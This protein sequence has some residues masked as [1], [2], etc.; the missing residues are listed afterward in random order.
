[1]SLLDRLCRTTVLDEIRQLVESARRGGSARSRGGPRRGGGARRA[2][3]RFARSHSP[4]VGRH[5]EIVVAVPDRHGHGD[6][7]EVEAPR[8]HQGAVVVVE[9]PLP[10]GEGVTQRGGQLDARRGRLERDGSGALEA[11]RRMTAMMFVSGHLA[12]LARRF[13]QRRLELRAAAT[14][15]ARTPRCSAGPIP[16]VQSKSASI[17]AT[18]GQR[19]TPHDSAARRARRTRG[20]AARRPTSPTA[21]YC[22]ATQCVEHRAHVVDHRRRRCDPRARRAAVARRARS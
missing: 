13:A 11:D 10:V 7:R 3:D 1:M 12:H 14:G 19:H 22:R 16:S 21:R 6:R 9:A 4:C 20:R 15:P 18:P 5:H 8:R 17:G 2:V